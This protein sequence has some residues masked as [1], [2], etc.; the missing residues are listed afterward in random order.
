MVSVDPARFARALGGAKRVGID[1]QVL[2]YHM[3]DV[4]PYAELTTHLL[5]QAATGAVTDAGVLKNPVPLW[6][7]PYHTMNR[8]NPRTPNTL[9]VPRPRNCICPWA[10]AG[11]PSPSRPA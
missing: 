2:I 5:T 1:T 10:E 8:G 11:V 3:Q 7:A 4:A 9:L 6:Y